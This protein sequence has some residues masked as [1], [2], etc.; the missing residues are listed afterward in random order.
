VRLAD[1]L[2]PARI[3]GIEYL[4]DPATPDAVRARAMAD[5]ARSNTLFGGGAALM[6]AVRAVMTA[7]P[8]DVT[9]LDVGTGHAELA[10]RVRSQLVASGRTARVVGLDISE[11]V[12][13]ASG[14]V[15]D[16]AVAGSAFKLPM[17]D[18]SVDLVIC[19]QLLHHFAADDVRTVLTELNRISRHAVVVADLR[20]SRLAAAGFWIA[21]IAL[22]FHPVTRHDGVVS[23]MRGFTES[24]L[25][26]LVHAATGVTPIMRR[27]IFWRVSASWHAQ[28]HS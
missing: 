7:L 2:A 24:E 11:S 17:R 19:S 1:K 21:S 28:A 5:V 3:R 16:G 22:G 20:R 4:D 25:A 6:S 10:A 18:R 27:G 12:A 13:R 26:E 15:L 8:A 14:R 9:V 23:V